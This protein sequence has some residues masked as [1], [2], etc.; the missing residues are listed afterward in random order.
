MCS[1]FAIIGT[2]AVADYRGIAVRQSALLQ[3]RGPDSCGLA[4]LGDCIIAHNRIAV[5]DAFSGGQPIWHRDGSAAV[6]ANAEIYNHADLRAAF[7]SYPFQTRSDCE[8]I[9]PIVQEGG[10][11][12]LNRLRISTTA[13]G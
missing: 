3:H 12:S 13:C 8:V 4:Q 11:A 6:V 10:N 1:I 2:Q 7:G 5:V 9:L